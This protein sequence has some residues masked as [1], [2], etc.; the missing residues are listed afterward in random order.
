MKW[1]PIVVD[2]VWRKPSRRLLRQF[3]D[4]GID[5][6]MKRRCPVCGGQPGHDCDCWETHNEDLDE[7]AQEGAEFGCSVP[8]AEEEAP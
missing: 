4:K 1:F 5:A 2:A 8:V 3:F 6:M 7:H